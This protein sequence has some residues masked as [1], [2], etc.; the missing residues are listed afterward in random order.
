MEKTSA[1]GD[2]GGYLGGTVATTRNSY[3]LHPRPAH[4]CDGPGN[5]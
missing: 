2:I 3:Q 4:A 5:L 1:D